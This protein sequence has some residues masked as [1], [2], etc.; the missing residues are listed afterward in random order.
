M[1]KDP[2]RGS[3]FGIWFVIG[4]LVGI[5]VIREILK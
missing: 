5:A 4:C 2:L 1:E 3:R